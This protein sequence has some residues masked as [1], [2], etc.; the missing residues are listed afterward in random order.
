[1]TAPAATLFRTER[2]RIEDGDFRPLARVN[3]PAR[4]A[5]LELENF[6]LA[7][8]VEALEEELRHARANERH[9]NRKLMT[10]HTD[11]EPTAR[12]GDLC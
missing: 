1:M 9:L 6:R 3:V 7:Q 4:V 12:C 11:A 5:E 10:T 2:Q 8:R